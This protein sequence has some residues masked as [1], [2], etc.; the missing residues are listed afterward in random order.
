VGEEGG[1]LVAMD[2]PTLITK[3]LLDTFVVESIMVI[4]ILP[5]PPASSRAIGLR[6]FRRSIISSIKPSRPRKT[7]GGEGGDSPDREI[8]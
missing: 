6:W 1:K 8:R 4:D 5:I 2:K 7:L 3:L